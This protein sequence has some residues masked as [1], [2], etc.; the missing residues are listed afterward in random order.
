M[1]SWVLIII[2]VLALAALVYGALC[3]GE[4]DDPLE[5]MGEWPHDR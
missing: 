5:G 3:G 4:P 1:T 2:A